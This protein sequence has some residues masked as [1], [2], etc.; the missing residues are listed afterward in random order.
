MVD[1]VDPDPLPL[2]PPPSI[3]TVV[4]RLLTSLLCVYRTY[5]WSFFFLLLLQV[6]VLSLMALWFRQVREAEASSPSEVVDVSSCSDVL[7]YVLRRFSL[8]LWF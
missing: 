6:T 7:T 3:S 4:A 5:R 2:P 1:L 8:W